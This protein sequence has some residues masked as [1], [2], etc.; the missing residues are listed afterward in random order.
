LQFTE[1]E[2]PPEED[3]PMARI[4]S[5]GLSA[6]TKKKM[7]TAGA[8]LTVAGICVGAVGGSIL[9]AVAS[10]KPSYESTDGVAAG[11]GLGVGVAFAVLGG[12]SILVGIPL[13]I[14]GAN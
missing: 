5:P 1:A 14:V 7:E 13:W 3:G 6:M 8:V 2:L 4:D 9:G 11:A 10:E 12:V